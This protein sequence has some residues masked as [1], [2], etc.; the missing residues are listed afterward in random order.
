MSFRQNKTIL[1]V[2]GEAVI[3]LTEAEI[4]SGFGYDV[5]T[6]NSGEKAVEL[7]TNDQKID[8]I[9]MDIDLGSGIDGTEAARQILAKRQLPIVF[10][11]AHAEKEYV[12]R[13]KKI[14]RY[15]YVIKNSGDFVLQSS[16]QM[17]FELFEA[18]KNIEIQME[19]LRRHEQFLNDVFE[20]IQDG[21][22]VLD[23]ELNIQHV[24]RVMNEWYRDNL[25]LEGKK[26]YQA[27]HNREK[28]CDPC[29]SLRCLITGETERE[30]VVGLPGSPI[31][32]IELFSYP[33]KNLETNKIAGVVE[34]VRD[35]TERKQMEDALQESEESLSIT[36]QS[37][38]DAVIAADLNGRVSLMNNVAEKLTGWTFPE[39]RNKPL[40]EVFPII[41]SITRETVTN[42]VQ[43]VLESGEIV[44]LAN[45]SV[46]ISR[47]GK[48]YQIADR[49]A[50]IRDSQGKIRGVI[51]TF[52][53]I[54]ERYQ[55]QQKLQENYALMKYIIEHDPNAIA[56]HDKDLKYMFV[57]ERY[58]KD[59]R[60][61][62]RDVI[63]KHH[64]EIFP[65]I[66]EK[67]RKVHQRALNG[68]VLRSDEDHFVRP[69]GSIDFTRWECRP[70]YNSEG[71]IGGIVL[72]TEV[73]TERKRIENQL[74]ESEQRFRELFE[75]AV[76]GFYRTTP[77]G[78]ILLAN[79]A[80]VN[81]LGYSSFEELAKR[82]LEK[83][84]YE[85]STQ[86]SEFKKA[87]E[88]QGQI[89]GLESVWIRKDGS[90]LFVRESALIVRDEQ[91]NIL[92]YEGT[93][94][95]I[96]E[97]KLAEQALRDSQQRLKLAVKSAKI[98]LWD[99]DFENDTII[100]NEEWAEMLGY[101]IKEIEANKDTFLNL[102]HPEDLPEVKKIIEAHE[103]GE[104]ELFSVENRLK[105]KNGQWKWVLNIGKIIKRDEKGK[106]LR[107]IGVHIDIDERKRAEEQ[108][109]KLLHEKDILLREVH[110]RIKNNM[111]TILSLLSLHAMTITDPAAI[112]ALQDA[113]SRMKSMMILYDKLYRSPD[114]TEMSLAQYLPSLI[115]EIVGTFPNKDL[116]TVQKQIEDFSVDVRTSVS[117]GII[118]NELITNAMKYAFAPGESGAISVS[119]SK[120]ENIATI[121]IED[122]GKGMPESVGVGSSSGFGLKLVEI[123]TDQIEGTINIERN[124]GTKFIL[125]FKV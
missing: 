111:N 75:N 50:P 76:I 72:Y 102:L 67:W 65:E 9:L 86:R 103:S 48:E 11:T 88:S 46:L 108:I 120:I 49:A 20:S 119:A 18:H 90:S 99:Q 14:T 104:S 32:W 62:R 98:G 43:K 38:G 37:I 81:L 106:P 80:L 91:G 93:V 56:V 13:V 15:G 100:R 92:Y 17:A 40:D 57:S 66:P 105:M 74:R 12:D 95:D 53:D 1:L 60:V 24:N 87:I 47:D 41:S 58:L 85:S 64:Y 122:N 114:F 21:I 113:K 22:S 16:I 117:I 5:I 10:L 35:I 36:L 94:E 78:R 79:P 7:A 6:A 73:I 70:W 30:I 69:D 3:A 2:E 96:T 124:R 83:D 89:K 39:A 118:V 68:E 59:Y 54:T 51:L 34:F 52:S 31:K 23:A 107:A 82:N 44:K 61:T 8:L 125:E 33:I 116:I 121:V 4:I 25:P 77:D 101:D 110:H 26:C 112:A 123:F 84:G 28:K 97:Q 63:G 45:D 27:Y 55:T 19:A 29:P 71:E 42:P 109:R 115:D